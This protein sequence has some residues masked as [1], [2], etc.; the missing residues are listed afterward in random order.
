MASLAEA[1]RRRTATRPATRSLTRFGDTDRFEG[2]AD[3]R[4]REAFFRHQLSQQQAGFRMRNS[5]LHTDADEAVGVIDGQPRVRR[6]L[7]AAAVVGV[8]VVADVHAGPA[9]D[10]QLYDRGRALVR[11]AVQRDAPGVGLLVRVE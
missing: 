4:R 9:I 3:G 7:L 10:E 11:G 8:A 6:E 2:A 5:R 1:Q